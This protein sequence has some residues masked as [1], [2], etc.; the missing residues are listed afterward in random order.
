[1][2][3]C[4]W[5]ARTLVCASVLILCIA[6]GCVFEMRPLIFL[7]YTLVCS[8]GIITGWFFNNLL[9]LKIRKR[10]RNKRRFVMDIS[11]LD[12]DLIEYRRVI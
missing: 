8:I 12:R 4:Q 1:M 11:P 9:E 6:L 2:K 5:I 10:N 3:L 7:A